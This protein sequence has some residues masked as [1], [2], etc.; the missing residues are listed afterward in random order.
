MA[1]LVRAFVAVPAAE[2][3]RAVAAFEIAGI[4]SSVIEWDV[5][6]PVEEPWPGYEQRTERAEVAAYLAPQRWSQIAPRLQAALA[7]LWGQLPPQAH[8]ANVPNRNWRTAWHEHFPL[9]R[10]PGTPAIVVRPPQIDYE[11]K[12]G[13]I[14][15]DLAPGLAF[16]TG[17]HQS[18]RLSLA[19]L[20][21]TVREGMSVLDVGTGSGILAVA[22]ANLGAASV[23][24]TDIDPLAVEAAE[25]TAR[26]NRLPERIEVREQSVPAGERFELVV[27]NLTADLLQ[28]LADELVAALEPGGR[29]IASGLIERRRDEVVEAFGRRGLAVVGE[30]SEDEWRGLVFGRRVPDSL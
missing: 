12:P 3:E 26:R 9:V 23:V 10:I 24:A 29:L 5:A 4:F 19:L 28:G 27:A 13:E 30:R 22:A 16:G 6:E 11:P 7:D 20:A 25:D 2:V 18:T 1:R 14:V 17:L 15:I 8:A 21:E